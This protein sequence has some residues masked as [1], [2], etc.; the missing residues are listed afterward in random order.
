MPKMGIACQLYTVRDMAAKDFADTVKQVARIG[1]RAVELAGYG[2]LKSAKEARKA[3]DDHGVKAISSHAGIAGMES[4]LNK[5]LDENET[6]GCKTTVLS[7][8]PEDRRKDAAGWRAAAQSLNKIGAEAQKRGHEFAYHNHSF[9]FQKFDGKYGL[10]ILYENTDPKLVKAEIDTY[11]VQHG[12]EDPVPYINKLGPRVTLL[13]LKDMGKG[14]D[15]RFAEVGTGILNFR[16]ILD[17]A[18]KLGTRWGIVEQDSTYETA[19]IDAVRTSYEN[20]KK[21][22]A[23]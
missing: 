14:A 10:D 7:W 15:K 6:L 23:V 1:Y 11:W 5:I 8:M 3:L 16:A 9:E 4:D 2:N 22:G 13:H 19:P 21:L 20:L 18:E 17:A 12:G